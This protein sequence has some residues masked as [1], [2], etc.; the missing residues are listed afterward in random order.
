MDLQLNLSE[1]AREWFAIDLVEPD[2]IGTTV[3]NESIQFA[4]AALSK[5]QE[6]EQEA[7]ER[8][9]AEYLASREPIN[10][11]DLIRV[12]ELYRSLRGRTT[13]AGD[14]WQALSYLL[15]HNMALAD[16]DL[17]CQELEELAESEDAPR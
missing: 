1:L 2:M 6:L 7:Q 16:W 5:Y 12:V 8:W 17:I 15:E 10:A 11:P 9:R 3:I 4:M 13:I 14:L